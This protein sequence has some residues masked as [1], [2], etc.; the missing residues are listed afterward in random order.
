MLNI[1]CY[2]TYEYKNLTKYEIFRYKLLSA[3]KRLVIPMTQPCN[4]NKN[5]LK[6]YNQ[7]IQNKQKFYMK[8]K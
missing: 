5:V 7:L 6:N 3:K 1:H 4:A 2:K 8:K